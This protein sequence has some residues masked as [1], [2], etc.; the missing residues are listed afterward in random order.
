MAWTEENA[1]RVRAALAGRAVEEKKMM[2]GLVFMVDGHMCCGLN[3]ERLMVRV[4]PDARERALAMPHTRP[5]E[6]AGR[7][8]KGFI[9]VDEPG[10]AA[11][12]ALEAWAKRGIDFVATLPA[13][14]DKPA[15]RKTR[16]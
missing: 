11:K 6:F 8:P 3:H 10:F 5:M 1:R 16:G 14:G 9:F 4:G 12:G 13:K 7:S 2:G 15:K